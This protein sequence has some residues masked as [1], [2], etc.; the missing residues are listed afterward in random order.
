[1]QS[2]DVEKSQDYKY[3]SRD[4]CNRFTLG[5]ATFSKADA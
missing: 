4:E 1:M 5:V 3:G 2:Y